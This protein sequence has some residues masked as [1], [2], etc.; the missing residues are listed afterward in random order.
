MAGEPL[1][2][3]T[4]Y[5]FP[6]NIQLAW[7]VLQGYPPKECDPLSSGHRASE[8]SVCLGPPTPSDSLAFRR[9]FYTAQPRLA[10][11]INQ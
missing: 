2:P 3:L 10:A 4:V 7:P 5:N 8:R 11:A 1:S 6:F 9:R